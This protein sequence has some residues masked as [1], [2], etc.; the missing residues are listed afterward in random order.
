MNV[1]EL[2][3]K[4]ESGTLTYEEF[5][6]L[7][8]ES[9]AKFVDLSEGGYVSK[10]KHESELE[11]K[12]KEVETLNGTISARDKD[13]ESLRKQLEEAGTDASKL[14]ELNAQFT[15]LKAKYDTDT[16]NYKKQLEGQ[17]FD[18][19]VKEYAN[20]LKF[21]SEAAKRE[22]IREMNESGLKMDKS[23]IIGA[24]DFKTRYAEANADSF[25]VEEAP[26]QPEPTPAP[27]VKP[28]FVGTTPGV[29]VVKPTSLTDMMKMA[30]ENPGMS[31]NF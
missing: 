18:F 10:G 21:T 7:A 16:K 15:E 8:K 13:L 4:T 17:A 28:Q 19:A 24:D 6:K 20:K 27:E 9:N 12:V 22:F 23:G 1:K 5:D 26:K 11:A 2:F 30:N 31:I 29:P 3:D 25:V 14:E